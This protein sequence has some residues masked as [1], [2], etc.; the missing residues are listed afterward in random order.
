MNP[1]SCD[2]SSA[3]T[4]SSIIRQVLASQKKYGEDLSADAINGKINMFNAVLNDLPLDLVVWAFEEYIKTKDDIPAPANI[5]EKVL[6]CGEYFNRTHKLSELSKQRA[7]LNKPEEEEFE[8]DR[9]GWD[10]V[11]KAFDFNEEKP[12]L[13]A[14]EQMNEFKK[15]NPDMTEEEL[16]ELER[17]LKGEL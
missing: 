14:K 9:E 7:L 4:T 8:I 12:K 3:I 11:L 10:K 6:N 13:T 2:Q 15:M 1:I 5:R 17:E 16:E